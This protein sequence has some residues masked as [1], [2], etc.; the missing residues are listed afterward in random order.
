MNKFRIMLAT[1]V[2]TVLL[3]PVHLALAHDGPHPEEVLFGGH[4]LFPWVMVFLT[5]I[6]MGLAAAW[7]FR[8]GR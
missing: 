7:M 4:S 5:F 8:S 2:T 6:A 3:W 1:L